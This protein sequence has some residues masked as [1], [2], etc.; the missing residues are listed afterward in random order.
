MM[1]V[2]GLRLAALLLLLAGCSTVQTD[3]QQQKLK[4]HGIETHDGT[5]TKVIQF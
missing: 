5:V 4:E 3:R 1:R 2:R